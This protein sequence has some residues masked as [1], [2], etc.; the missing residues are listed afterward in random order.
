MRSYLV[1]K[2]ISCFIIFSL[3]G[4]FSMAARVS[5]QVISPFYGYGS[6]YFYNPF[7]NGYNPFLAFPLAPLFPT[8]PLLYPP[9]RTFNPY[10]A[11]LPATTGSRIG[12][13]TIILTPAAPVTTAAAPLGTLSL[14]PSTLVFLIL[15]STLEE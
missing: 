8:A 1:K 11:S 7:L 13:A 14:T 5:A 9:Y 10:V 2:Y 6:S 3:I 4:V 15:L 12:A